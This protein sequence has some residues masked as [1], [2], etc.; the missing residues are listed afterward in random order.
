MA[1]ENFSN[2]G[3]WK[4]SFIF[5]I[6]GKINILLNWNIVLPPDIP[7]TVFEF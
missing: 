2:V 3:S 6:G 1:L 4:Q 5:N 7:G